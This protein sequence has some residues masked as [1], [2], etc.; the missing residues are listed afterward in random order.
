MKLLRVFRRSRTRFSTPGTPGAAAGSRSEANRPDLLEAAAGPR[1]ASPATVPT[2][3]TR[4]VMLVLLSVCALAC[5]Y[6]ALAPMAHDVTV[7][8]LPPPPSCERIASIRGRAGTEWPPAE[9]LR[10]PHHTYALTTYAMNDLRNRAA[11][12]GA[13]YV[14]RSEPTLSWGTRAT[15]EY[16]GVAYLCAKGEGE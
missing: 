12:V 8:I 3:S 10:E 7:T 4:G 2:T 16:A 13:N 15:A 9:N 14:Q 1:I 5:H 6:P 11:A